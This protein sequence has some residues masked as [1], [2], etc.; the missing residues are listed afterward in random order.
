MQFKQ[1]GPHPLGLSRLARKEVR[2]AR[3]RDAEVGSSA[4]RGFNAPF[5][6]PTPSPFQYR[7]SV[8]LARCDSNV[9]SSFEELVKKKKKLFTCFYDS[10]LFSFVKSHSHS[11]ECETKVDQVPESKSSEKTRESS[12]PPLERVKTAAS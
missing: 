5:W 3:G 8:S 1:L 11:S 4:V 12:P 6:H 2:Q 9:L 10:F 7:K